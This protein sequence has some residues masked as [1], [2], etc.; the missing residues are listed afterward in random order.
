MHES[1]WL[2]K[3]RAEGLLPATTCQ[4]KFPSESTS[5]LHVILGAKAPVSH[6]NQYTTRASTLEEVWAQPRPL[7]FYYLLATVL[8]SSSP[9]HLFIGLTSNLLIWIT[10]HFS[11]EVKKSSIGSS[12]A[13]SNILIQRSRVTI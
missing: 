1:Q 8:A 13:T 10:T 12:E 9:D 6:T 7:I 4:P 5:N 11:G 3:G 2:D